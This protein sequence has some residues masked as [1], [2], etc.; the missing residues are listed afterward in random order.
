MLAVLD[1][2]K[3][4]HIKIEFNTKGKNILLNVMRI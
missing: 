2:I 4:K 3:Q 1:F